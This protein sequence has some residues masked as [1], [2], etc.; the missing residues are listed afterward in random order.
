ML[1]VFR[2]FMINFI[3]ILLQFNSFKKHSIK[4]QL[5]FIILR[6]ILDNSIHFS[7]FQ[8]TFTQK[9]HKH[10][11]ILRHLSNI[12]F[13]KLTNISNSVFLFHVAYN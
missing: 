12:K 9:H 11:Q 1:L 3:K 13:F 6:K 2:N 4:T 5:N 7:Q 10:C 8:D